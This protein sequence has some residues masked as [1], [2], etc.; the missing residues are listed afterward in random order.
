[1]FTE[2]GLVVETN[3]N[4]FMPDALRVLAEHNAR[5]GENK[6]PNDPFEVFLE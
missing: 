2:N 3:G 1:M 6:Q 5:V 4:G